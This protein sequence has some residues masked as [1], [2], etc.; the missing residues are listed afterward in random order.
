M[1][2]LVDFGKELLGLESFFLKNWSTKKKPQNFAQM[3]GMYWVS[4]GKSLKSTIYRGRP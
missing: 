1:E 2:A 4:N 3:C